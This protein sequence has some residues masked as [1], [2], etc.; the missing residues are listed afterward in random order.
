MEEPATL[1]SV[2]C[3]RPPFF[4]TRGIQA[5]LDFQQPPAQPDAIRVDRLLLLSSIPRSQDG[6][7]H[8]RAVNNT[9]EQSHG[10]S[11][12]LSLH[13]GL[14]V[15]S[16]DRDK[17]RAANT[18]RPR[19]TNEMNRRRGRLTGYPGFL[20]ILLNHQMAFLLARLPVVVDIVRFLLARGYSQGVQYQAIP[21]AIARRQPY[22]RHDR[23][24][25]AHR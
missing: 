22:F 24:R 16:G 5:Q 4:P 6:V 13:P 14:A 25:R 19:K 18:S 1:V 8:D 15:S 12:S 21:G 2:E 3:A 11:L 7:F 9:S 17:R 10:P 23:A 20:P